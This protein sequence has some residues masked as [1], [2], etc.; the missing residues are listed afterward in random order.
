MNEI[1]R[2]PDA[3]F[4]G[5]PGYPFAPH[6]F[7]PNF[8]DD[9]LPGDRAAGRQCGDAWLLRS[10]EVWV[11]DL[12]GVSQGMQEEIETVRAWNSDPYKRQITVRFASLEVIAAWQGVTWPGGSYGG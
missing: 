2:T 7:Y 6:A 5:L 4:A 1:F 3:H 8:L 10:T 12:W 9:T 11:W